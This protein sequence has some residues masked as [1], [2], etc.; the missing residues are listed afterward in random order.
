VTQFEP[1]SSRIDIQGLE[2]KQ[3]RLWRERKV[4]ARTTEGRENATPYV[5]YEGPPTANGKPGIHHVLARAFKDLFPRYKIMQGYYVQRKGGWDTHGLPVEI[6][7]EKELGITRKHQIDEYG[8]AAFNKKCRESVLRYL[9]DWE[10]LTERMGF[11]VSLEDAYVT[12]HNEY[13]ESVWGLLRQ[14]FEKNLLYQ[15][16]K[17]VPYCARCGTPLSTH[18]ISDAYKDVDD[19]SVF[20]RFT[21]RDTPDTAILVWTTTPWT[22]PGNVALAVGKD[23]DYALVEV[24]SAPG[25]TE[26]L[27]LAEA[28]IERALKKPMDSVKVLARMKGSG[29][30]GKHYTPLYT[31]LPVSQDY[32]YVVDGSSF[33]STEDGTG[34]VHIAP[35]FG[36][37]D[38]EVGRANRLPTLRTVKPDGTFV[39][40]VTNWAGE[41]VK[42]A[43][44][45]IIRELKG[46]NLLYRAEQ[47]RHSYP[48]CW[49]CQSPLLYYAR[50]TWFVRVTEQRDRLIALN[51]TINWVPN[52]IK[53]GRFGMWLDG[54]RDW[55]LGRERYWGTP[56]PVWKCTDPACT[57]VECVGSLKELSAKAGRD[58]T[59]L[60]LH[61]PYV[62]EITWPCPDCNNGAQ[63]KRVVELIDVWFDSGAM[64]YAQWGY[65]HQS[66]EN[67]AIFAQQ[68][69]ADYIC[70]AIDQTRGWFYSLHAI[71]GLVSDSV[72]YKNVICLGHILDENG[73]K[74][75]K[76]RGNIV[77]PWTIMN[78]EGADAA[79]WYMYTAAPPGDSRRFSAG[80]VKDVI[81]GFYLTLWN[82]YSFFVSYAR[83]DFAD[84][85]QLLNAK[86][87][88]RPELDR[89]IL[90]ELQDLVE[91]V[92]RGYETYDVL[93]CTRP[94]QNFVDDL[95]NW[96][97]RRSRRRFWQANTE[98]GPSPD[99][100]SAYQTLYTCLVTVAKLLAPSMPFL[101][102]EIYQNLVV[103][104]DPTATDSIHLVSFPKA[105]VGLLDTSLMA[106][107]RLIKRLVSLG[108][109]ARNSKDLKVRQPLA[110]AA[111]G[112]RNAGEVA[113]L[114]KLSDMVAE[115]L[116]VKRV[117]VLDEDAAG[118]M[119][120]YSLNP[121]PQKLGKRLNKRFPAV[122]KALRTGQDD[123]A[124]L[125]A[126]AKQLLA[127]LPVS[128]QVEGEAYMVSPDEVE[129]LR[130]A[131][132][133]FTVAEE[134][135]NVA[136]LRTELTEE[137]ILEGLARE[138]V[139]KVNTMRRD[140]DYQL[141][142]SISIS[143]KTEGKL[144][145]AISAHQAYICDE[146]LAVTLAAVAD[147]AANG[148]DRVDTIEVALEDTVLSLTLAVK[149][150]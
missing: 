107:M 123:P 32:A 146:T 15:D 51:Q 144:A 138:V 140:A 80:L 112:L 3:L 37:D 83:L 57:R 96:Y 72:A 16:Y 122:Q 66:S 95:S 76:S 50:E 75:S 87:E 101:A 61:R 31:F 70:E 69:P 65:P 12:F 128:L 103:N 6:E 2:Q 118:A 47:Y 29:L 125:V 131:T 130:N 53:D 79:R 4:F 19:P 42:D 108:H 81:S 28:L 67:N 92:T 148:A 40:E 46:R 126:W 38:L 33:V 26:K 137:L 86:L 88:V 21:L 9:E 54:L 8:V 113:A 74:M 48:F 71:A 78:A 110:E 58:L 84:A 116:N 24:E 100:A 56:L 18:E 106:E 143:Y 142:D 85:S 27:I 119:I 104:L 73:K 63:M 150:M 68:F 77:N 14:L 49:R 44:P 89:W 23:V 82:T 129:V 10:K 36:S 94:I 135:G 132:A 55:G 127:G 136:A 64:P 120:S 97:L 34:I 109:A 13:I 139:R 133:G 121:L 114:H 149:R 147:P 99:K 91:T 98:N 20:V 62:D 25:Q 59:G 90:S 39:D 45:K 30:R 22:L 41:W 111:F 105:D 117:V 145:E 115:E 124:Q 35:A 7:V 11:W 1:V 5:F 93:L 52:H 102:E 17:T 134:G 141:T 43:D 60:D